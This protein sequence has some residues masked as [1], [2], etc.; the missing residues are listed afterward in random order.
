LLTGHRL[1]STG[2][3]L[4]IVFGTT[5]IVLMVV[6]IIIPYNMHRNPQHLGIHPSLA[7]YIYSCTSAFRVS[8]SEPKANMLYARRPRRCRDAPQSRST[9]A[10]AAA[11]SSAS[12]RSHDTVTGAVASIG[13]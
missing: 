10:S 2:D 12:P 7:V 4:A 8:I 5:T 11:R 9:R 1:A 6:Q 3:I 13:R